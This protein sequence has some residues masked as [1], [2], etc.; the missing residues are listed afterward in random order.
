[1]ILNSPAQSAVPCIVD[2]SDLFDA[3]PFEPGKL[4]VRLIT[5]REGSEKLQIRL[6]LGVLQMHLDG[7]P[8]GLRPA[9]YQSVLE[10][11]EALCDHV[12]NGAPAPPPK[13][14]LHLP[15]VAMDEVDEPDD[16]ED[17]AGSDDDEADEDQL[18]GSLEREDIASGI[19]DSAHSLGE[20]GEFEL[21]PTDC[22]LL[23]DEA[24]QVYH[25]YVAL[26]VLEDYERVVRDTTRNL[27]VL[28]FVAEHAQSENDRQS[29]VHYRPYITMMRARAIAGQALDANEP[30]AAI[31]AIDQALE[32][33][34]GHFSERGDIDL[35]DQAGE[36]QALKAM[37]ASLV[38]K[39]PVSL[40]TELQQRLDAALQ[41]ENYEL[42]AIL[43]DELGQLRE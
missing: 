18:G 20:S 25:R 12:E 33:L 41:Q 15:T 29:L 42:A 36:V 30:K 3:W 13:S 10:Y 11:F 9:G 39:L 19:A 8:D 31:L 37:R 40:K 23:R 14:E 34:R 7:R 43:R 2:L 5:G 35:F 4:N 16:A 21:S 38:P 27:R 22:R 28:D 6:D 32:S 17:M 26:L 24:V 1:M